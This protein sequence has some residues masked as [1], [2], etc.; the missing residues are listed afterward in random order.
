[1]SLNKFAKAKITQIADELTVLYGKFGGSLDPAKVVMWAKNHPQSALYS[2]FEW[3]DNKAAHRHRLWQARELIT[4]VEVVYPDGKTH[5][6]YVS[7]VM[8]RGAG[9]Y[10]ALADVLSN[11]ELRDQY[12]K[13]AFDELA[14]LQERY[15]DLKELAAIWNAV[16]KIKTKKK[17]A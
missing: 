5:Q 6:V 1:M 16:K 4:E 3:D 8:L 2:R 12:L 7:P 10:K 15:R 9:G 13:Q 14:R 17:A 11:Q